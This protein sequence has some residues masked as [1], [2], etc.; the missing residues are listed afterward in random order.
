MPRAGLDVDMRID[1]ALA[2]KPEVRQP[3]QKR[4]GNRRA[5]AKEDERLGVAQ[6]FPK[7][8]R[9]LDVIVPDRHVMAFQLGEA[10]KLSERVEPVVKNVN[11]HL[12][13]TP[14]LGVGVRGVGTKTGARRSPI[15]RARRARSANR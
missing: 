3:L 8:V 9:V 6:P 2:D 4:R 7:H 14:L 1:A 15:A 13:S 11:L 12:D 5:L 10:R